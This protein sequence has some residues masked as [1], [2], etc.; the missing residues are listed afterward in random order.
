MTSLVGGEEPFRNRDTFIPQFSSQLLAAFVA[1]VDC[2]RSVPPM[3]GR[4]G[5]WFGPFVA[6][7]SVAV[8]AKKN[9][10]NGF[11]AVLSN[12]WCRSGKEP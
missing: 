6:I 8:V 7:L 3:L 4:N 11:F 12:P 1:I 2:S 9:F 10:H 5:P